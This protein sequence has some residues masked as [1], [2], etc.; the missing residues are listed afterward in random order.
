MATKTTYLHNRLNGGKSNLMFFEAFFLFQIGIFIFLAA[1]FHPTWSTIDFV[2]THMEAVTVQLGVWGEWRSTNTSKQ[3]EWIP[4]FP[5]PKK[6]LLRLAGED[7]KHY[8]R[9]QAAFCVIS[10][11]LMVSNNAFSVYT[12]SHYRYIYKRLVAAIHFVTAMCVVVTME[13]LTNSINEWNVAVAEKSKHNGQW[14]F[15]TV[16]NLGLGYYL[17]LCVVI[18]YVFAGVAFFI[19][20]HKQK[21]SRAAT[22][23]LEI[24]DRSIEMGR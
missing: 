4:H 9:A 12:L 19:S 11:A 10:L 8:Y 14:N 3:S 1:I 7:L 15:S 23:Q 20:S 13:V 18:I 24:D 2:N 5:K 22:T 21:G 17:A 16:D 6:R